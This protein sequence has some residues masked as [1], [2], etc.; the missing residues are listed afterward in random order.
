[1]RVTLHLN[2]LQINKPTLQLII[3]V[4]VVKLKVV[5]AT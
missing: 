1:M 2:N 4:L 5:D 3:S